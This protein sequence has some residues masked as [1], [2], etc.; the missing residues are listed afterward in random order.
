MTTLTSRRYDKDDKYELN[1]SFNKFT[2][3][4]RTIEQFE[5]EWI[6][7]PEGPGSMW[8]LIDSTS[9]EIVGHH[10]LIPVKLRYFGRPI[11]AGKTENTFLHS[12]YAGRGVYYPFEAKFIEEA[13]ERFDLLYTIQGAGAPG[14]I[15]QKLGYIAVSD[16]ADYIKSTEISQLNTLL[17]NTVTDWIKNKFVGA[18]IIGIS[19][20]AVL[21]MRPVFD[22][23]GNSIKAIKL[24]K[25]T[26]IDTVANKINTFWNRNREK[27]EITADR[28]SQYIKWRVFNNPHVLYEFFL[29]FQELEVVGYIV[30]QCREVGGIKTVS[31][32]DLVA[33]DN[34]DII[35]SS[36]LERMIVIYQERG[37][38]IF[39]FHTLSCNSSL[40]RS[41][42]KN[43]FVN[44]AVLRKLGRR[45]SGKREN[46]TFLMARVLNKDL[47]PEKIIDAAC[48]YYTEMLMEGIN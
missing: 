20:L 25:V 6:N 12:R 21:L 41:I 46:D 1:D 42:K 30:T 22:R 39:R 38:G 33:E 7:T 35:F 10:G 13:K 44:F 29:A 14:R 9:G 32:I 11:I 40:S 26:N 19:S 5:W 18:L 34:N 4:K 36:I 31:I 27:F 24:D 8:V 3:R 48:W 16:Y 47:A 43:G 37:I 45:I 17:A 2:G 28:N 23:K 15:R